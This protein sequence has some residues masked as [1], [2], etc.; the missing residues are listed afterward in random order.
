MSAMSL[1]GTAFLALFLKLMVAAWG[2]CFFLRWVCRMNNAHLSAASRH[3]SRRDVELALL[4]GEPRRMAELAIAQL[5]RKGLVMAGEDGT[6]SL[7]GAPPAHL[8]ELESQIICRISEGS[9]HVWELVGKVE[10][11]AEVRHAL[12]KEGLLTGPG[13]GYLRCWRMGALPPALLMPF[14]LA[15]VVIGI[16][17]GKPVIFL[18]LLM[19][20]NGVLLVLLHRVAPLRT[21]AGARLYRD[22]LKR[23]KPLEL[24]AGRRNSSLDDQ[25]F[26]QV[27][28]G[29]GLGVLA[30]G[31]LAWLQAIMQ[32]PD[33][34]GSSDGGGG[35]C[36][37]GDGGGDGGGG[38]GGC[39]GGD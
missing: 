22:W 8:S 39:G 30:W 20:L 33:P 24:T 17:L 25:A 28:A 36:S 15:K 29:F 4:S 13:N 14:G 6:L 2:A 9:K 26:G 34:Q 31:E 23:L 18:V 27:V 37:G 11:P 35:G 38:C 16:N 3:K 12:V 19:I 21:P 1:A 5:A 10:A 32:K 7:N